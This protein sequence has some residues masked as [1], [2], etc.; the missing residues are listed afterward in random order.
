MTFNNPHE[1]FCF[2]TATHFSAVRGR[3]AAGT[4]TREFFE[5]LDAAKDYAKTHGDGRTMVYAI[6]H[7]GNSAHIMN[8]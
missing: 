6:N 2:D 5:T 8:A 3:I 4:R 7:L 1:Q